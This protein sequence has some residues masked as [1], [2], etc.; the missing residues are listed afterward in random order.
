VGKVIGVSKITSKYQV[1]IPKAVRLFLELN[2]GDKLAFEVE[3]EKVVI[4][5]LE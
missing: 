3:G 4:R 5:R 1:T 2:V